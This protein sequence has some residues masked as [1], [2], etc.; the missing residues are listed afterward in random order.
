MD[1]RSVDERRRN[2]RRMRTC[3]GSSCSFCNPGTMTRRIPKRQSGSRDR[4]CASRRCRSSIGRSCSSSLPSSREMPDPDS[5]SLHTG[6]ITLKRR[7]V[8]LQ[9]RREGKGGKREGERA[10][11]QGK[12]WSEVEVVDSRIYV[13][14][15]ASKRVSAERAG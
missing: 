10:W 12:E 4:S 14:Y 15:R 3:E 6:Q 7:N 9:M 13:G 2:L 11:E 8:K 5:R 1:E